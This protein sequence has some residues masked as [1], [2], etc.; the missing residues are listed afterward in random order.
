MA[1]TSD[2]GVAAIPQTVGAARIATEDIRERIEE[3]LIKQFGG[4][5]SGAR[6]VAN[7]TF[8]NVYFA[9][10]VWNRVAADEEAWRR[11]EAAVAKRGPRRSAQTERDGRAARGTVGHHPR[12]C[13][14]VRPPG[15][16][17]SVWRRNQ[18]RSMVGSGVA[19]GHC[20]D[21]RARLWRDDAASR[22]TGTVGGLLRSARSNGYCGDPTKMALVNV[23]GPEAGIVSVFSASR[24]EGTESEIKEARAVANASY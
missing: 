22:G 17:D 23:V 10:G 24:H 2:H 11:V 5:Q 4:P 19:R 21:R 20:S 1:L 16:A 14:A 13:S 15:S 3:V 7:V 8:T 18:A 12:D 9:D 6:Y